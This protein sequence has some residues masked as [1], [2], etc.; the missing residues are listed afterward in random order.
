MISRQFAIIITAGFCLTP[1]ENQ[2][3][4]IVPVTKFFRGFVLRGFALWGFVRHS[5]FTAL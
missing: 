2:L 1:P 3:Q 5:L 4:V